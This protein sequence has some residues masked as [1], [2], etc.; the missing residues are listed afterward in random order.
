MPETR[1]NEMSMRRCGRR[2]GAKRAAAMHAR[3]ETGARVEPEP[4]ICAVELCRSLGAPEA[5]LP[6]PVVT[7]DPGHATLDAVRLDEKP[8]A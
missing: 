8:G 6:S 3:G 5:T 2:R 7:V 1:A 4:R